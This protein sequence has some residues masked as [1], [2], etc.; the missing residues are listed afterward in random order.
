MTFDV[1]VASR[2][3]YGEARGE[4][5]DGMLAVAWV[6]VNRLKAGEWYSGKTLAGTCLKR[7]QFSCWN[8]TDPN[9]SI[10]CN[11]KD[12]DLTLTA[13]RNFA[14]EAINGMGTDPTDGATFY[15]AVGTDASWAN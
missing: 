8:P 2:T 3:V 15:K 12:T 11:L 14:L 4:V 9:Y 13:C 10:L 1:E 6:L 5:N 7:E